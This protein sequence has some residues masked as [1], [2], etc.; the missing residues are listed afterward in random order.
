VIQEKADED[1]TLCK[2]CIVLAKYD[3]SDGCAATGAE[4]Q[5]LEGEIRTER[6][7]STIDGNFARVKSMFPE[8]RVARF[9]AFARIASR[10]SDALVALVSASSVYTDGAHGTLELGWATEDVTEKRIAQMARVL[11]NTKLR[12]IAA[13]AAVIAE[14]K[15]PERKEAERKEAEYKEAQRKEA[16]YTKAECAVREAC[17]SRL[18]RNV[19]DTVFL[20]FG[21]L[22]VEFDVLAN[23]HAD[24]GIQIATALRDFCA[25]FCAAHAPVRLVSLCT[26]KT[27]V[28]SVRSET[29]SRAPVL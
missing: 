25:S 19:L 14:R 13:E 1:G 24:H 29:N 17:I 2:F 12:A 5:F 23:A 4:L 22:R 6:E 16:E 18:P 8:T 20:E 10:G 11:R 3:V 26:S 27:R 28:C 7:E 15:E 9:S 21:D